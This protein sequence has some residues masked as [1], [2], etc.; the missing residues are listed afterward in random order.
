MKT[1]NP[2]IHDEPVINRSPIGEHT[3]P[4]CIESVSIENTMRGNTIH[5]ALLELQLKG[6]RR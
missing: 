5:S 6:R 1:H 3:T 2:Q 4:E